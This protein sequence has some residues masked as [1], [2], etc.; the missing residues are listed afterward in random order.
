MQLV[1][2]PYQLAVL[3]TLNLYGGILDNLAASLAA[4]AD[5]VPREHM[6]FWRWGPGSHLP[7]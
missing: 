5:V 2:N 6:Q 1:Q 7:S 3:L 4:V